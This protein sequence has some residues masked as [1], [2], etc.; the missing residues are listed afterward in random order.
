M[1]SSSS[2]SSSSDNMQLDDE[3]L[4]RLLDGQID[5]FKQSLEESKKEAKNSNFAG[6]RTNVGYEDWL[7]EKR[8]T[9]EVQKDPNP[10]AVFFLKC[11]FEALHFGPLA[12]KDIRSYLCDSCKD[13][14]I[15]TTGRG[16]L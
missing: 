1:A 13:V 4:L 15:R 5:L 6:Y 11:V 14:N 9:Y 16:R 7:Q 8:D 12:E 3:E 2:S 10:S